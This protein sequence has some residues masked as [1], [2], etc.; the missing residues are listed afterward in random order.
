MNQYY[1]ARYYDSSVGRFY[2]ED[3][4]R[5]QADPNFY[6]YVS[7]GPV[8][9]LDPFGWCKS[10]ACADCPG[11]KWVSGA[12]TFEAYATAGPFNAG[13]LVFSGVFVCSSN[14]TFNVPFY[15]LCGFGGGGLSPRPP[16]TSPPKKPIGGGIGAGGA[17]V[18]CNG[19]KCRE[20]MYGTEGGKFI[21]IGPFYG[22]KEGTSSGVSCTGFG[23]GFD[24]GLNLGGFKCKT[25][26][27]QSWTF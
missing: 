24:F 4:K 8:N 11:G 12:L 13:G 16:L 27:G 2:A 25:F 6:Q 9:H 3:P 21:Q 10:G 23:G 18:T 22:F 1:R 5:F 15:T 20:D 14:P 17:V 19:A 26:I 7:N